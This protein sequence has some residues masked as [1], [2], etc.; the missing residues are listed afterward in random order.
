MVRDVCQVT[1]DIGVEVLP[2]VPVVYDRLDK[3][4]GLLLTGLK[5]WIKWWAGQA[6][7]PELVRLSE[8]AGSEEEVEGDT[9]TMFLRPIAVMLKSQR[10]ECT[11]LGLRGNMVSVV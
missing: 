6:G 11:E 8:T 7:R 10:K 5:R 3:E 4:G 9:V 2:F 1:G